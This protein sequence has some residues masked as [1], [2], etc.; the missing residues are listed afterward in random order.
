MKRVLSIL[1]FSLLAV[2]LVLAQGSAKGKQ[3]TLRLGH[4]LS[5]ESIRHSTS[6]TFKRIVEKETNGG[7]KVEIYPSAQ[8]G[9]DDEMV[10][11]VK[12]GTIEA[13]R[14]S[15][16]DNVV[17]EYRIYSMPFIFAT[18]DEALAVIKSDFGKQLAKKSEK[19]GIKILATGVGGGMRVITN[20]VRPIR[21]PSDMK[22][23]KMR[24]PA[25]ETTIATMKCLG[26]NVVSIPYND[27]YMALKTNVADGE[28]NPWVYIVEPK[29]YEVQKYASEVN[30]QFTHE[31]LYVN[32]AWYKSLPA[33]YQKI[34]E[35]AA[36]VAFNEN[37]KLYADQY[38]SCYDICKAHM[39]IYTPTNAELQQF[40]DVVKP[41]YQSNIDKGLFTWDDV[42][43][44]KDIIAKS[45]K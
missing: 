44:V 36:T 18:T 28:E 31:C 11:Q 5:T 22:G 24:T 14:S 21:T 4:N 2:S 30:W 20:N 35:D 13:V 27:T 37:D 26:A 16:I 3:Y 43:K 23:L 9:A 42:A 29:F 1:S 34:L 17:P 12:L 8:L 19:N 10:E 25:W 40:K 41:V 45:K 39:Q 38:R 7:I 6:E 33:N 32:L 15:A